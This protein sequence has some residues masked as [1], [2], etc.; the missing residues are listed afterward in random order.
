M[1]GG[2]LDSRDTGAGRRISRRSKLPRRSPD[3]I[4]KHTISVEDPAQI[5]IHHKDDRRRNFNS[6]V[7]RSVHVFYAN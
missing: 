3:V 4:V 5:L 7:R 2:S 6:L 1:R